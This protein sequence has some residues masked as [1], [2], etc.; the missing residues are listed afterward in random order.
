M[1]RPEA[2]TARDRGNFTNR[3]SA[4]CVIMDT[5]RFGSV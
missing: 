5:N 4:K 3:K 2:E 1:L